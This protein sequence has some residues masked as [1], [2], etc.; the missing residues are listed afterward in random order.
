M[1]HPTKRRRIDGQ[2]NPGNQSS[3]EI[4]V[5]EA[6]R[7]ND[8]KLK[9]RFESIFEKYSKDFSFVGD[10]IDLSTG[11]IIINNGHIRGMQNEQDVGDDIWADFHPDESGDDAQ[12]DDEPA[13][14]D[15]TAHTNADDQKCVD[16]ETDSSRN[17]PETG[18]HIGGTH[19]GQSQDGGLATPYELDADS[20][21]DALVRGDDTTNDN[22]GNKSLVDP[23]WEA[24]DIDA[25]FASIAEPELIQTIPDVK[26]TP[27]PSNSRSL[28]LAPGMRRPKTSSTMKRTKYKKRVSKQVQASQEMHEGSDSDDPLQDITSSTP[29]A[30]KRPPYH[31]VVPPPPDDLPLPDTESAIFQLSNDIPEFYANPGVENEV[32]DMP[33]EYTVDLEH[34]TDLEPQSPQSGA[35]TTPG[36]GEKEM[37]LETKNDD[38]VVGH[39]SSLIPQPVATKITP[40]FLSPQE[41]KTIM[42]LRM[43]EKKPWKDIF[44]AFPSHAPP[45]LKR[46][47]YIQR[48]RFNSRS[49]GSSSSWTD[50]EREKLASL[51]QDPLDTWTQV[52]SLFDARNIDE[53]LCEW[54]RVCTRAKTRQGRRPSSIQD[55]EDLHNQTNSAPSPL[56]SVKKSSSSKPTFEIVIPPPKLGSSRTNAISIEEN[57]PQ[58]DK[59][60][61]PDPLTE[62]F[63]DAWLGSGLSTLQVNTPPK[64]LRSPKKNAVTHAR[65]S[66][67]APRRHGK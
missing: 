60:E 30:M 46:W 9:S 19:N 28:W 13:G 32:N 14:K 53:L 40:E 38:P 5:G 47:Y 50:A 4:D 39:H 22:G 45:Q 3:Q 10:E 23:L 58:T 59:E 20:R 33:P 34:V 37:E 36:N 35:C 65:S 55:I 29:T 62:A 31:N 11:E 41:V 24:P 54:I 12:N 44:T 17:I 52:L 2:L 66:P 16:S 1:Q 7:A 27:S 63:E 15:A 49:T 67:L 51:Q 21:S 25:P 42:N 18:E 6:R 8:L 56:P 57:E 43:V 26:R 48:N 64:A 61:S